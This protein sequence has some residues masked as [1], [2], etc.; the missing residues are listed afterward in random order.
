MTDAHPC[1]RCSFDFC[2]AEC[3]T[4]PA[5]T[6]A[7]GVLTYLDDVEQLERILEQDVDVLQTRLIQRVCDRADVGVEM[8]QHG[9]WIYLPLHEVLSR[10]SEDCKNDLRTKVKNCSISSV[11][12]CIANGCRLTVCVLVFPNLTYSHPPGIPE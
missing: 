8:H 3:K 2:S 12:T 1:E 7:C 11:V 10:V 4:T 6:H 9:E 5:K